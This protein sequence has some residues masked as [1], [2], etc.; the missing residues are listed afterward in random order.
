MLSYVWQG[1]LKKSYALLQK[2]TAFHSNKIVYP[3]KQVDRKERCICNLES[4]KIMEY[5]S[6]L[7][8]HDDTSWGGA[9]IHGNKHC[10]CTPHHFQCQGSFYTTICPWVRSPWQAISLF[11]MPSSVPVQIKQH[12]AV[13]PL[14]T[15][16]GDRSLQRCYRQLKK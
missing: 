15:T 5:S 7:S 11:Q 12:F 4:F 6:Y 3:L 14:E 8:Q 13:T 10:K 9:I 2:I 1:S 16:K